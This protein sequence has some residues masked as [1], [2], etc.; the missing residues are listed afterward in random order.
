M[1]NFKSIFVF[2]GTNA[3]LFVLAIIYGTSVTNEINFN[4]YL[5]SLNE[6]R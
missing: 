5:E 2:M 3:F 6:L 1:R 4:G